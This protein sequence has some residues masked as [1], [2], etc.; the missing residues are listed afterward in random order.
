[1]LAEGWDDRVREAASVIEAVGMARVVMLG[2][3]SYG[4]PR[5]DW[6]AS[7]LASRKPEQVESEA[8]A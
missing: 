4:D 1:M 2:R 5:V 3:T 6:V 7:L 8:H